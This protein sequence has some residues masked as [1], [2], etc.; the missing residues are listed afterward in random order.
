MV[1]FWAP[2][3]FIFTYCHPFTL[4]LTLSFFFL[5]CN[6]NKFHLRTI[7]LYSFQLHFIYPHFIPFFSAHARQKSFL[8]FQFLPTSSIY[9]NFTLTI[10]PRK[11][12]NVAN[13]L[14]YLHIDRKL[15]VSRKLRLSFLILIHYSINFNTDAF[16][17]VQ[18]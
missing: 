5:Q 4:P 6:I 10:Y 8:I 17:L 7:L 3:S 9:S 2:L 14:T 15:K 18:K 1:K 12:Q 11:Q 16:W 13:V